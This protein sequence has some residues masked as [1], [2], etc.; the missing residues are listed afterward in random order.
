MMPALE[1]AKATQD[2]VQLYDVRPAIMWRLARKRGFDGHDM[3]FGK[4]PPL[5]AILDVHFATKP[6]PKDVS[7]RILDSAGK[8]V[9]NIPARG[10]NL[11]PL[12]QTAESGRRANERTENRARDQKSYPIHASTYSSF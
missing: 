11:H 9:R 10:A 6:D 4:N 5:G 12:R 7:I 3:F 2:A 1:Q 8:L